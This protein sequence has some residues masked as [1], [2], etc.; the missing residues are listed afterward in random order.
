MKDKV[1][2]HIAN[3]AAPYMGN[4][5][6]S[7]ATLEEALK[8]EGARMIYIFP[9]T[10]RAR[11]WSEKF[12]QNHQVYFV[13]A[14]IDSMKV[15]YNKKVIKQL[16]AIFQKEK[17]DI[18]HSHYD[19][20][21]IP[22]MIAN[23][24]CGNKAQIIWHYR[25]PRTL[26]AN[27]IKRAYQKIRFFEQYRIYGKSA[28]IIAVSDGCIAEVKNHGFNMERAIAINNGVCERS[29]RQREL[30]GELRNEVFTF[31]CYGGRGDHKG[32]DILLDAFKQLKNQLP[33]KII[34]VRG[35]D[36]EEYM[37]AA[38]GEDRPAEIELVPP[39]EDIN[40]LFEQ[41]DC[42]ISSSR[43]ETFSY[44]VHEAALHGIPVISSEIP[45][46]ARFNR[47][48]SV[49]PFENENSVALAQAMKEM[50]EKTDARTPEAL[51]EGRKYVQDNLTS[52]RWA[53]KV[54]GYYNKILT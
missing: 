4:F 27:P 11:A 43:R 53:E 46:L 28:W 44:A 51:L 34:L 41:V 7:L 35:A 12:A 49:I 8:A 5:V 10:C 23:R 21:D 18:I 47:L 48:P 25:N 52:S 20:Y 6:E 33:L 1:I 16:V 13:E 37:T 24:K 14:K 15:F 39:V 22:V 36:T 32:I 19:G 45:V 29:I 38:F 42:F 31:L 26:V 54:I 50:I 30:N 9:E 17:P 2:L 40:A 3:F